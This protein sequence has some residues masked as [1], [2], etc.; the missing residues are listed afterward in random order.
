MSDTVY[1]GNLSDFSNVVLWLHERCVP[2][3]R[4]ITFQNGEEL[5][6][7]GLPL[8]I[9]F[10]HP[11][12]PQIKELFRERVAADIGSHKGELT[13]LVLYK[14]I[15]ANLTLTYIGSSWLKTST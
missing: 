6:E 14:W 15:Y 7:E 10:Y 4:E 5:T 9:L 2:F 13:G 11:D 1:T 3:V 8:L 12:R